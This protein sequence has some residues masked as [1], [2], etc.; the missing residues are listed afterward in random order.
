MKFRIVKK[1]ASGNLLLQSDENKPLERKILFAN[2]KRVAMVFDTIATTKKPFYL[3]KPMT[4]KI[5][6]ML[7]DS[8]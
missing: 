2:G 3:A 8:K 6:G 4:E 5:E 1:T 7:V